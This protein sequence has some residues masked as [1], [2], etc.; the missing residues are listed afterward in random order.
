MNPKTVILIVLAVLLTILVIQNTHSV[1]LHIFFW[2]PELPLIILIILVMGIG[3]GL[4]FF[5][6][7]LMSMVKK[8]GEDL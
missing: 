6:R 3:V 4:G 2:A 1:A 5:S 7:N 8:N